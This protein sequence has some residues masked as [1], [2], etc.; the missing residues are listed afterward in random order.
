VGAGGKR[1]PL[2]DRLLSSA[3]SR[4]AGDEVFLTNVEKLQFNDTTVSLTPTTNNILI[5]NYYSEKINGTT[6]N[7]TL[8]PRGGHDTING[9]A[10]TDTA[11]FFDERADFSITTLSGVTRLVGL[12]SAS[13]RYAYDE[14]FLTNVE[15]L[16]FNDTT[17]SLT[18]TTNNILIATTSSQTING[19][20]A[21][22]TIDPR[23]GHDT[24]D[25]GAGTDTA[26][27]FDDR[28][29]FSITTLSGVTRLVGLSSVSGNRAAFL[30]TSSLGGGR[31]EAGWLRSVASTAWG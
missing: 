27:F 18:P 31:I 15:K 30:P 24:I 26:I 1:T 8:D 11:I 14:V 6:A 12:S 28:A 16:Q 22:D 19:T 4:Y 29:D 10:G 20:S 2:S 23:G 17:V 3:S 9:G 13:N 25:G 7:D 21:N 5:A